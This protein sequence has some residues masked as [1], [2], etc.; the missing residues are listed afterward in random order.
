MKK[1]QSAQ[2]SQRRI[3]DYFSL[4]PL[5]TLCPLWQKILSVIFPFFSCNSCNSWTNI[6]QDAAKTAKKWQYLAKNGRTVQFGTVWNRRKIFI[7]RPANELRKMTGKKQKEGRI[8]NNSPLPPSLKLR[9]TSPSGRGSQN[10]SPKNPAPNFPVL[11]HGASFI[12]TTD[13]C[14]QTTSSFP[15]AFSQPVHT[16]H[17][18][19]ICV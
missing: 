8:G 5:C 7:I 13:S 4:N 17:E 16:I 19:G 9:W 14:L 18:E 15:I 2:R 6:G 1:P 12:L 10:P 11:T 3:H